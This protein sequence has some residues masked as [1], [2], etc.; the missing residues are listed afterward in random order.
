VL[1]RCPNR[2]AKSAGGYMSLE[3]RREIIA[4]DLNLGILEGCKT[5]DIS[6]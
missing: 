5:D 4:G 2:D 1:G 3:F 6:Y